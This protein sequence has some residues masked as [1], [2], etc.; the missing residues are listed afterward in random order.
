MGVENIF[1]EIKAKIFTN[2]GK[3][4]DIQVLETWVSN[5]N[6]K[7]EPKEIHSETKYN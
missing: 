4:T 6:P 3:E 1:E 5:M 2:H 7:D